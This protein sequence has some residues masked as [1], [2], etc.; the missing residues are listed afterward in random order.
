MIY[1]E[2]VR[3]RLSDFSRNGRLSCEAVLEILET[4]GSHHSDFAQDSLIRDPGSSA[5]WILPRNLSLS[6]S[7]DCTPIDSL[8]IPMDL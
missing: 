4:A 6:L 7:M 1:S 8:L 5:V 2:T 3:P